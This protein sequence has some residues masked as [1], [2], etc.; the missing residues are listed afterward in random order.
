MID[1]LLA[2]GFKQFTQR[3][4]GHESAVANYQKCFR[5]EDGKRYFITV[6]QYDH[7]TLPGYPANINPIAFQFEAKFR[8][9]DPED[10]MIDI[11][12]SAKEAAMLPAVLA[13]FE[14]TWQALG[15]VYYE[16]DDYETVGSP[17]LEKGSAAPAAG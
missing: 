6:F 11:S 10:L 4:L 1:A 2:A 7:S 14:T 16:Q 17:T 3:C 8:T 9:P 15:G 12:I 5:A 13:L